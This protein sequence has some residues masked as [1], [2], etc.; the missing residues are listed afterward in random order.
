M[1]INKSKV[2][3]TGASGFLGKH[4]L[5]RLFKEEAEVYAL[6]RNAINNGKV[7]FYQVDLRD[8]EELKKVVSDINPDFVFHLAACIDKS[9]P[10]EEMMA[11]N[12]QGTVNLLDA[13]DSVDYNHFVFTS[14]A[15]L[16]M[17]HESP[18]REDMD[19]EGKTAYALSK[20]KAEDYC[21]SKDKPVTVLRPFIIY[22]PGQKGNMFIPQFMR[23]CKNK[24]DFKMTKGEQTRDF[25]YVADVVDALVKSALSEKADHEVINVASGVETKMVDVAVK[26]NELMGNPIKL[27]IGALPYRDKEIWSYYADISNAKNLLAW[28]PKTSLEEG[29]KKTIYFI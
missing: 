22:G 19:V 29:L 9:V 15:E 25:I 27:D 13:L 1:K 26:I 20:L 6:G 2:L 3:V 16:Y 5:D 12:Y 24:E 18:F 21:L 10:E 17:G 28:E 11:I 23:A 4:L 8:S 7:N 14:T